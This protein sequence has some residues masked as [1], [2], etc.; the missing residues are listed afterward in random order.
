MVQKVCWLHPLEE[1]A[2]D[3]RVLSV[4]SSSCLG[5]SAGVLLSVWTG[6]PIKQS[7][8]DEV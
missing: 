7:M 8:N 1:V 6:T 4:E 5:S 3:A 2:S